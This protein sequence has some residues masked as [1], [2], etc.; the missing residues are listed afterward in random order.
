MV[1]SADL[2]ASIDLYNLSRDMRSVD[3]EP[4]QF[5]GAIF[6]SENPKGVLIIFKNGKMICTK[7]KT[8]ADVKRVLEHVAQIMSKYVVEV[9]K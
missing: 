2:H 9:E 6:R 4:D 1:A 5:P 7:T 8:E 3:Y